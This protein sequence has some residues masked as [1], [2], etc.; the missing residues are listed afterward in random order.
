MWQALLPAQSR[1]R[2]AGFKWRMKETIFLDEIERTWP[3]LCN[4][5]LLRVLQEH[6]FERVGDN[7]P[8]EVD[9]PGRCRTTDC[10]PS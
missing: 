7:R 1:I 10:R 5:R 6:A 3:L 4:S 9:M 2:S 8:V